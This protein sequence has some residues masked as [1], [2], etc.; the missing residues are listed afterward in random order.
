MGYEPRH[1]ISPGKPGAS[2]VVN[3]HLK[4]ATGSGHTAYHDLVPEY[5]RTD[6]FGAVKLARPVSA[7]K[8]MHGK[9]PGVGP[10]L[11]G[12]RFSAEVGGDRLPGIQPFAQEATLRPAGT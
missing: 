3:G 4:V 5:E 12:P 6:E 1:M 2:K 10:S 7:G 8:P 9:A 11:D